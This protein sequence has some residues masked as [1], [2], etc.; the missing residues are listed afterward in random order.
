MGNA[1]VIRFHAAPVVPEN[2]TNCPAT[3]PC[4]AVVVTVES[5]EARAEVAELTLFVVERLPDESVCTC[6][7]AA[8]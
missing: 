3:K 2:D 6:N 7:E 4:A 1:G 5:A 8:L